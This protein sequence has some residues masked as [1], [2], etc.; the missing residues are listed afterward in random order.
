MSSLLENFTAL[1][2]AFNAQPYPELATRKAQLTA[3]RQQLLQ[4]QPALLAAAR[5]DFGQR[6][7]SETSLLEVMPSISS[8]DYSLKKLRS[9]LKPASRHV[10]WLFLPAKNYVC[11]QPL[12]VVGVI[13]PWNYPIFLSLGPLVTA[14]SAG[15]K[16]MVK[17]SEF[18]PHTNQVLKSIIEQALPGSA[19]VI[20]G[21][22]D[23]AA[24]FSQLPF[25][26]LLYTGSTAVGQHVMRA[27]CNNLTPVTLELGGKSPLL[28]APDI[29]VNSIADRIM[30]GK[31]ANAGQT[32]VAP[33]YL[34]VPRAQLTAT[35]DALKLQF[36]QFYP[37][38]ASSDQ[39]TSQ[40]KSQYT[41]VI[42]QRHFSRLC[43]YLTQANE[44]GAT[45]ISCD[46]ND[47]QQHL[48]SSK[49]LLP[50]QLVL[51]APLDCD[52]W[53]QEIFGPVLPILPYDNFNEALEF[54]RQRPRPL[55]LYLF[56]HDSKLQQQ[57]LQQTHAG[58]VCVNET[59]LHVGQEDLPF[60][61]IGPSGMGHYHGREGFL[62]FSHAKAV[63]QKGRINS[64][65]LAYPQHRAKL[66]NKVMK[67][68]LRA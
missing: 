38:D 35:I 18:T 60:G 26:H 8:I 9:W 33:D 57:V 40:K 19:L 54:V 17:L 67:F 61:G 64:T 10:S 59:L 48:Q 63:H 56:S 2:Q 43:G 30:F 27:A 62:T 50:L 65:Q 3:L 49:R 29:D 34:L 53:Q 11:Y 5:A 12:G 7:D 44:K 32:C 46:G 13:V 28:I 45:V 22:A 41:S 52:L 23:I 47:W 6:D 16:V 42:N 15:N 36:Q 39:H 20:E 24:S 4:Q 14:I 66:L 68:L 51:D 1:R 31:T 25:D 21:D 55:A 58:G 37:T